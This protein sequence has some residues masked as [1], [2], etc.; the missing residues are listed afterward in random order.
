MVLTE[1]VTLP[2]INSIIFLLV[3][4]NYPTAYDVDGMLILFVREGKQLATHFIY[5]QRF[6]AARL[7]WL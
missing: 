2:F 1:N 6:S 5:P 4:I 3:Y 7:T